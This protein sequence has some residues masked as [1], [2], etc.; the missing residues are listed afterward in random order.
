M[1]LTR[2]R[3][4]TAKIR[5]LPV[6]HTEQRWPGQS[7][8][9]ARGHQLAALLSRGFNGSLGR[10]M[11]DTSV[12]QARSRPA[13]ALARKA[14]AT[15]VPRERNLS[16]QEIKAL[17]DGLEQTGTAPTLR[18]AVRFMLL[19]GVR[20]GEFIDATL[21]GSGLVAGPVVDSRRADEGRQAAHGL[22]RRAGAR[23]PDDAQD[24][25]PVEQVRSP[26]PSSNGAHV[27]PRRMRLYISPVA[28]SCYW[29][30]GEAVL[31]LC[32]G[33]HAAR[34]RCA[35]IQLHLLQRQ[36][37]KGPHLGRQESG[38]GEDG[39]HRHPR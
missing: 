33:S 31:S 3:S 35:C 16:R 1:S 6:K 10:E 39:M 21:V 38:A 36:I 37:D 20:K 14:Y 25:L 12:D 11:M 18:L 5:A 19:T 29:A 9:L 17:L 28:R 23:H 27:R 13:G 15:F 32:M 2:L 8:K 7:V 4:L 22:P 24:L 30:L 34:S 26:E